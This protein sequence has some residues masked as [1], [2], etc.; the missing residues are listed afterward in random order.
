MGAVLDVPFE[1]AIAWPGALDRYRERGFDIVALTPR[2]D[3][4]PLADYVGSVAHAR[5]IVVM[6]GA[7]GAGL[8]E[9]ALLAATERVKIPI[10]PSV[11]SLNVTVAA[12]I[13]LARLADVR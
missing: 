4:R 8:T 6:V 7:E 12:G 10:S 3:A 1:R 13:A 2:A 5:R 11:D 9:R